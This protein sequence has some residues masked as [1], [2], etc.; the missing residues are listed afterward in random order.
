MQYVCFPK[1]D[2]RPACKFQCAY[3]FAIASY[4]SLHLGDPVGC[5]VPSGQFRKAALQIAPMPEVTVA[6]D[7]ET[8]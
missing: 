5:I 4:V 8:L 1:T 6:K 2:H 3:V 7:H